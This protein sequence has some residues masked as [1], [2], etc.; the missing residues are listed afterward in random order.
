M[1]AG[2]AVAGEAERPT[3]PPPAG[4]TVVSPPPGVLPQPRA[5]VKKM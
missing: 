5:S 4:A 3:P 1:N 2:S